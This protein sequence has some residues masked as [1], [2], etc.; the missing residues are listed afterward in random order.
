MSLKSPALIL[1]LTV[2]PDT[3]QISRATRPFRKRSRSPL[4]RKALYPS[5]C[6]PYQAL[7]GTLLWLAG[8]TR[9]D[10]AFS[11]L[12][13]PSHFRPHRISL[14]VLVRVVAYLSHVRPSVEGRRGA[15]MYTP[16][17]TGRDAQTPEDPQPVT[18]PTFTASR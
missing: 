12:S 16:T 17:Q 2:F 8:S 15:Y 13:V 7:M 5:A 11:L 14:A 9:P 18:L 3:R 6:Q 4:T 10:I 1:S